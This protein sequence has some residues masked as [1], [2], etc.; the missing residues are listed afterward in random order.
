MTEQLLNRK[1]A[2][3]YLRAR[4]C[5]VTML[6]LKYYASVNNKA[7]N[8]PPFRKLGHKVGYP[9]DELDA[10]LAAKLVEVRD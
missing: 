1:E 5:P 2:A 6:T 8:G 7:R 10:W 3:A 9:R 4:G